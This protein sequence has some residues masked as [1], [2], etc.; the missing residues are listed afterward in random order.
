MG[1][2]T[3]VERYIGSLDASFGICGFTVNNAQ[4]QLADISKAISGLLE[5][6]KNL[7]R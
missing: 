7:N 3:A 6:L 4:N 1:D 5:A 2:V